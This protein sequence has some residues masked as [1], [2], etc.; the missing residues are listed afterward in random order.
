MKKNPPKNKFEIAKDILSSKINKKKS[1]TLESLS[2]EIIDKGGLL[3][4]GSGLTIKQSLGELV[5]SGVLKYDNSKR[6][7]KTNK[8]Y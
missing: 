3:R 1:F 7:Y 5:Y 6:I 4:I 8:T 2:Q